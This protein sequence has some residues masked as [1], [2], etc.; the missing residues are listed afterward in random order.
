[1]PLLR[2]KKFTPNKA[3]ESLKPDDEVFYCELTGE[4]FINYE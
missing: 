4:V 2:K 3:P 1:M